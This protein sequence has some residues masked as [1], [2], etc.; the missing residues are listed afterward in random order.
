[1]IQIRVTPMAG[2]YNAYSE[3][4]TSQ[5]RKTQLKINETQWQEY[6]QY[7]VGRLSATNAARINIFPAEKPLRREESQ[8]EDTLCW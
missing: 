5:I 6:M 3:S 8:Q 1:M 7:A 4:K 2:K